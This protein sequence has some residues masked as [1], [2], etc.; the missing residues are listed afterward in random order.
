MGSNKPFFACME[1]ISREIKRF[2][3]NRRIKDDL[4]ISER[5]DPRHDYVNILRKYT[6]LIEILL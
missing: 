4:K 1:E 3:L 5:Y 2:N 6:I